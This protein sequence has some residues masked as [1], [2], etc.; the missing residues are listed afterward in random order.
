MDEQPVFRGEFAFSYKTIR[1]HLRDLISQPLPILALAVAFF[2]VLWTFGEAAIQFTTV[3]PRGWLSYGLLIAASVIA[4]LVWNGYLYFDRV[5][6]GFER[7]STHARR[8]AHLQRPLWEFHLAK[9]LLAQKLGAFERE[10]RDMEAGRFFVNAEK[11]ESLQAYIRWAGTRTENLFNM[12]SVAKQLILNDFPAALQSTA[13]N[14]AEPKR[15]LGAVESLA[16]F[17]GETVAFERSSRAVLP[18][19]HLK[20]LHQLQLGWSDSIRD[21]VRQLFRFLQQMCE[22]DPDGE[23]HIHFQI[24]FEEPNGVSQ[25]SEELD[26]LEKYIPDLERNW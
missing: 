13:E 25:F 5:P 19:E 6:E 2:S 24:V 21:G 14:P 11:P 18:S 7:V 17:Y 3:S 15:I 26:R 10:L 20:E 4:S 16:R 12:L 23:N 8:I 22:C 9:T 1:T